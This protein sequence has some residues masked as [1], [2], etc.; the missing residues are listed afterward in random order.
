VSAPAPHPRTPRAWPMYRAMVGVGLA[1]G[2]VLATVFQ[3]TRPIVERKRA[4]ALSRAIFEVLPGARSSRSFRFD[5]AA[6]F[7]AV[8]SDARGAASV[9]VGYDDKQRLVGFAVEA[10]GMGYQD[11]IR[12]LYG[13][14]FA[15]DAIVGLRVLESRETPGLGDRVETDAR[16]LANFERL[17]VALTEDGTRVAHLIEAVRRGQKER[18]WQVD[19]ITGATV[20]STAIAHIL[21][22]STGYWIPKIRS[23]LGAFAEPE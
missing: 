14:S 9:H 11:E 15:D 19:A 3:L 16:F 5:P 20:T 6:G 22:R 10:K 4:A 17:D 2:L 8:A 23:H 7:V 21:S 1:C 13:Y 12:L 18:P